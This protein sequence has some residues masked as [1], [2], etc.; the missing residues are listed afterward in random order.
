MERAEQGR[1]AGNAA[2]AALGE[3]LGQLAEQSR[4][5]QQLM[6]RLAEAQLEM[7]PA[8]QRFVDAATRAGG[9]GDEPM[10]ASLRNLETLLSRLVEDDARRARADDAGS[11]RRDPAARAHHRR[12]RRGRA[13]D[14]MSGMPQDLRE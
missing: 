11:A 10:R 7:K 5:E 9:G 4:T 12:A 13:D 8:M 14:A 3:R 1:G 2:L 6:A